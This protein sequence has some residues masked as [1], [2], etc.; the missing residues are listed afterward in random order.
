MASGI[1]CLGHCAKD[2]GAAFAG[3]RRRPHCGVPLPDC[4]A[5]HAGA[6]RPCVPDP[7]TT[8]GAPLNRRSYG[9]CWPDCLGWWLRQRFGEV[10][11]PE[12]RASCFAALCDLRSNAHDASGSCG[13]VAH[14]MPWQRCLTFE[15][16]RLRR[17]AKPAV[18]GR[19]QRR[20]RPQSTLGECLRH[21]TQKVPPHAPG[22]AERSCLP[23]CGGHHKLTKHL[24]PSAPQRRRTC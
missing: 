23:H 18:A 7:T 15:L 14:L 22:L 1:P 24:P 8:R 5:Q 11:E 9:I 19:L 17:L 20:V 12:L 2:L 6:K 16:S 4:A 21:E 10:L 3:V 13:S